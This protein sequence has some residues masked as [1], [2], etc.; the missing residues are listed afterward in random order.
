MAIIQHKRLKINIHKTFLL[1][2][3]SNAKTIMIKLPTIS[4]RLLSWEKM[5]IPRLPAVKKSSTVEKIV[6]TINIS[7]RTVQA[8]QILVRM[9]KS[10]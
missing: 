7:T 6:L 5:T 4:S 2:F 1:Y 9:R 10:G 8:H 3:D